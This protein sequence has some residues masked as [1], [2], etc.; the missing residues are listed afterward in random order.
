MKKLLLVFLILCPFVVFSQEKDYSY[1]Y[2]DLIAINSSDVGYI[3]D[4]Y[5]GLP[6]STY[7]K[8]SIRNEDAETI[9]SVYEK[10]REIAAVGYHSSI[11]D[12]FK[13]VSK[14]GFSFN[15]ARVMDIY[16]ELGVS[17]WEL[18]SP[19]NEIKTGSDLYAHAGIKTGN[20]D[21]WEFNLFLEST[22]MADVEMDSVT[23]KIKYSLDEEMNNNIGFKF[24][25][26]SM[27][28]LGYSIGLSH[29]DFSGVTPSIGIRIRL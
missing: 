28:N 21:G 4:I 3:G 27:E 29:D 26:H 23:K 17:K 11:A 2:I 12:L 5:F 9:N 1:T 14:S 20:S 13:N 16:A 10:S 7:L 6:G 15:F 8:G 18:E 19:S 22:K 25:N 24:I